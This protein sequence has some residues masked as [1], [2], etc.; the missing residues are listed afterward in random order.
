MNNIKLDIKGNNITIS[1]ISPT[2][3]GSNGLSAY[4][5]AVENGFVGTEKEW[6]NSL[7]KNNEIEELK[8]QINEL[9]AIMKTKN[10]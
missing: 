5:I 4:E 1:S 7:N 9:K 6:I 10:N 8:K 2:I 3:S